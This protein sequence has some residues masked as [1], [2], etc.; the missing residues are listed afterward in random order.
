MNGCAHESAVYVR[1]IERKFAEPHCWLFHDLNDHA[2]GPA[3]PMLSL[4][5]CL[6]IGRIHVDVQIWQQ[7]VFDAQGG[8]P[9]ETKRRW[10]SECKG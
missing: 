5:D 2:Y 7:Y 6:R 3:S 8:G 10:Q 9:C 4:E 1:Q